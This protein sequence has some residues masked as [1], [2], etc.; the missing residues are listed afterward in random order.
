[1]L[2]FTGSDRKWIFSLVMTTST[3]CYLSWGECLSRFAQNFGFQA[4]FLYHYFWPFFVVPYY[5]PSPHTHISRSLHP[6]PIQHS[7]SKLPTHDP[8]PETMRPLSNNQFS[9]TAGIQSLDPVVTKYIKRPFSNWVPAS[10][11]LR[12]HF[13]FTRNIFHWTDTSDLTPHYTA[14]PST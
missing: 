14:T 5:L 12:W 10:V 8:H 2:P 13:K 4:I 11:A 1:M 6:K 9:Q 7:V 3:S